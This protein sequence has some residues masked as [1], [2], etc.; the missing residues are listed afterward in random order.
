MGLLVCVLAMLTT[1]SQSATAVGK[2]RIV[3]GLVGIINEDIVPWIK[4]VFREEE[5]GAGKVVEEVGEEVLEDHEPIIKE[6]IYYLDDQTE[7]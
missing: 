3:E 1:S 4:N 7:E 5:T 2:G 6:I